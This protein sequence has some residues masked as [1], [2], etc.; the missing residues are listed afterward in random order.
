M[1]LEKLK[2]LGEMRNNMQEMLEKAVKENKE[3]LNN[4]RNICID[5]IINYLYELANSIDTPIEVLVKHK[6]E[7]YNGI[8][9]RFNLSDGYYHKEEK[10]KVLF[11]LYYSSSNSDSWIDIKRLKD[12][13]HTG[14]ITVLLKE[15]TDFKRELEE[16]VSDALIKNM[17]DICNKTSE[18]YTLCNKVNNFSV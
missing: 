13:Y 1:S 4:N 5:K 9:F 16:K 14:E 2:A 6:L 10:G 15:W 8:K 7:F 12:N 3:D 17:S 11:S 18:F